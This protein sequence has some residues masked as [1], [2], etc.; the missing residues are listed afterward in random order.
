MALMCNIFAMKTDLKC[1]DKN[2]HNKIIN[3]N[4]DVSV[5]KKLLDEENR[6]HCQCK[7]NYF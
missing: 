6:V 2:H 5:A 4:N 1:S 3:E 7:E